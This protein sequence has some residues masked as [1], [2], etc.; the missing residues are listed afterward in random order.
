ML[1]LAIESHG[2]ITL[3]LDIFH[4]ILLDSFRVLSESKRRDRFSEA[5]VRGTQTDDQMCEAIAS[6][7]VLENVS[8]F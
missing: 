1:L 3:E 8:Q 4:N 5:E 2:Q 6:K 7:A